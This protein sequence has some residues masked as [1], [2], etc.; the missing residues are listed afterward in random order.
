MIAV[1]YCRKSTEAEHG[2]SGDSLSI[3]EQ[4]SSAATFIQ[5]HGWTLG[6]VFKDEAVSGWTIPLE[7]RPGG[8]ALLRAALAGEFQVLVMR[9]A[10]RLGREMSDALASLVTLHKLGVKVYYTST[11]Q[12]VSLKTAKD[13]LVLSIDHFGAEDYAEKVSSDTR[14]GRAQRFATVPAWAS[15]RAPYGYR[16]V[17]QGGHGVLEVGTT[18][19]TVVRIFEMAAR[20]DSFRAIRNKLTQEGVPGPRG[21]W[22]SWA[23]AKLLR[24]RTYIGE[25]RLNGVTKVYE[26]LRIVSDALFAQANRQIAKHGAR[27]NAVRSDDLRVVTITKEGSKHYGDRV[28]R[29]GLF[30]GGAEGRIASQHLFS[31]LLSCGICGSR[32]WLMRSR[33]RVYG[34]CATFQRHGTCSFSKGV[35]YG[36]LVESILSQ[37]ASLKP[38]RVRALYVAELEQVQDSRSALEAQIEA[39]K[40]TLASLEQ[41][42]QRLLDAL[43]AGEDVKARLS[44]RRE[45]IVALRRAQEALEARLGATAEVDWGA[46]GQ[47]VAHLVDRLRNPKPHELPAARKALKTLFQSPIEVIPPGGGSSGNDLPVWRWRAQVCW[48]GTGWKQV[49]LGPTVDDWEASY[50]V[51]E[52]NPPVAHR[53]T[54]LPPLG[55]T[56]Q[57]E[58]LVAA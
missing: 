28:P 19:T 53:S 45:E 30:T 32:L 26:P 2:E 35:P 5:A 43:E 38:E 41:K 21:P 24:N 3:E 20:G 40:R 46:W 31:N 18:A 6:P 17:R 11:G 57:I 37:I 47:D 16:N 34:Y 44:L 25:T 52:P 48:E 8:K 51:P 36:P 27:Y 50:R 7:Q 4:A 15:S 39:G 29:R 54:T 58:G 10:S 22:Q 12:E 33:K 9:N 55:L 23:L 49:I 14:R 13:K 1:S 56:V 42:V